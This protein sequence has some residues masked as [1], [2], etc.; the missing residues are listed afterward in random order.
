MQGLLWPHDTNRLAR[1]LRKQRV[2]RGAAELDDMRRVLHLAP[3]RQRGGLCEVHLTQDRPPPRHVPTAGNDNP[4]HLQ[5]CG[6]SI[7]HTFKALV[8]RLA[9]DEHLRRAA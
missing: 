1:I 7:E 9:C 2:L 5:V 4:S 3:R 6:H 8:G